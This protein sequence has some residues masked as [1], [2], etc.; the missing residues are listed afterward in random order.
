MKLSELEKK[1]AIL[2]F[3]RSA[4]EGEIASAANKLVIILRKR[5]ED[6][7]AF[8]ADLEK[9]SDR[10]PKADAPYWLYVMP[11]GK[12]KGRRLCDIMASDVKWHSYLVWLCSIRLYPET[13]KAVE[14]FLSNPR[15]E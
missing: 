3:N 2:A 11:F 5:F 15:P 7:Y 13:R 14:A 10:E 12:H 1:L 8:I 4:E 9:V 6:G